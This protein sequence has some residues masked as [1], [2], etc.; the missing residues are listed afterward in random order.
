MKASILVLGLTLAACAAPRAQYVVLISVDGLPADALSNPQVHLPTLRRLAA[1]GASAEGMRSVAPTVT[2]PNHTTLV[3]GVRPENHGVIG[4]RYLDRSTGK[5]VPLIMDPVFDKEDLVR[6]PT[7]YDVAHAAG[8]STAGVVWPA[9]RNAKSL[10][11]QIPDSGT[12][13]IWDRYG[14]AS[15]LEELRR[16]GIWVDQ[17]ETWVKE[18]EGIRRDW[19]YTKAACQLIRVHHPNLLLLHLIELDH[20][21]HDKGPR[22][23]DA[24]VTAS[25]EDE[26]IREVLEAVEAAGLRDR[27]AVFV[28]SDHGFFGFTKTIYPA[29]ALKKAGL[30]KVHVVT[31]GGAAFV[32]VRDPFERG[33]ARSALRGLEGVQELVEP[34]EYPKWGLP[35]PDRDPRMG[36]FILSAREG[37]AFSDKAS[38]VVLEEKP[39]QG[40][41]GALPQDPKLH[42]TLIAWGAGIRPGVRLPVIDNVDVAPTLARLLGLR[43]EHVEGTAREEILR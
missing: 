20:V 14:T 17:Q 2:W 34:S 31:Q 13:E 41:H 29:V 32:Y 21:Q 36:D 11:W 8:L 39:L 7:I 22:T 15:W 10:D 26:R 16:S 27:T 24:Y 3:T 19:M 6:C 5:V 33:P 1:E 40:T 43:M 9:S 38:E 4:N 12:K 28:V 30:E 35:P 42:A 37:Y 18:K 23:P 25:F